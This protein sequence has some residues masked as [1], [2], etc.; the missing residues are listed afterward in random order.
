MCVGLSLRS[1]ALRDRARGGRTGGYIFFLHTPER[2]SQSYLSFMLCLHTHTLVFLECVVLDAMAASRGLRVT[3]SSTGCRFAA[4]DD[5]LQRRHQLCWGGRLDALRPALLAIAH[6]R[7]FLTSTAS[8]LRWRWC[9]LCLLLVGLPV[10]FCVEIWESRRVYCRW[11][12]V[13]RFLGFPR[14]FTRVFRVSPYVGS[15]PSSLAGLCCGCSLP[16]LWFGRVV[17]ALSYFLFGCL[18]LLFCPM[19]AD[20]PPLRRV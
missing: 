7:L 4:F 15:F 18:L 6:A 2:F 3:V 10:W 12:C 20:E 1:R 9:L 13:W 17:V 8:A 5:L 19:L 14:R 16:A 11:L